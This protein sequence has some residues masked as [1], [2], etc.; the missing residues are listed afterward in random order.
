[1]YECRSVCVSVCVSGEADEWSVTAG[2]KAL[3]LPWD[4]EGRCPH[5]VGV[6]SHTS[7]VHQPR[8]STYTGPKGPLAS[9]PLVTHT[10]EEQGR[11]LGQWSPSCGLVLPSESKKP[12]VYSSP[13]APCL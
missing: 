10:P 6:R 3:A 9:C 1:M 2:E 4:V 11:V 5:A 8:A 7:E 12:G 13:L